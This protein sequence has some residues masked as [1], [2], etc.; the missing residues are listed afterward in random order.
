MKAIWLPAQPQQNAAAE[1]LVF[2]VHDHEG[3]PIACTVVERPPPQ[4]LASRTYMGPASCTVH[5]SMLCRPVGLRCW[6]CL[7]KVGRPCP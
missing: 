5:L 2:E 6:A 3:I 4:A 1:L 7:V